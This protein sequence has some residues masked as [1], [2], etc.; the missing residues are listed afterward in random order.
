MTVV[1]GL[2]NC[3]FSSNEFITKMPPNSLVSCVFSFIDFNKKANLEICWIVISGWRVVNITNGIAAAQWKHQTC[4]THRKQ[5]EFS[6]QRRVFQMHILGWTRCGSCQDACWLNCVW[7]AQPNQLASCSSLVLENQCLSPDIV[8]ILPCSAHGKTAGPV[9]FS[10][11]TSRDWDIQAAAVWQALLQAHVLSLSGVSGFRPGLKL[12]SDQCLAPCWGTGAA[13]LRQGLALLRWDSRAQRVLPLLGR[14]THRARLL[15]G[16]NFWNR[17][18]F[19]IKTA[20]R[21][22]RPRQQ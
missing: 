8:C 17:C 4:L 3:C 12:K 21:T 5:T 15:V 19:Q 11:T 7:K 2:S 9:S 22:P 13:D 10:R 20:L 18:I 1:K 6:R 14:S 16:L